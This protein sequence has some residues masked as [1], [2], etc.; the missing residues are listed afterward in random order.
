MFAALTKLLIRRSD[1]AVYPDMELDSAS[2]SACSHRGAPGTHD[3]INAVNKFECSSKMQNYVE[4]VEL[5]AFSLA[6]C[7]VYL[8][9]D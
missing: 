9:V 2:T 5:R 1:T 7:T 4:S 8:H 3:T 6:N